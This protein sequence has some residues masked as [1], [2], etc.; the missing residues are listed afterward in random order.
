MAGRRPAG[1][2]AAAARGSLE[3]APVTRADLE[4]NHFDY[5]ATS[6]TSR[7]CNSTGRAT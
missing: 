1:A 6:P 7:S 2:A 3:S 4:I 5:A